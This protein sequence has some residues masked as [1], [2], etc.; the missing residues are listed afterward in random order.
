MFHTS[1]NQKKAGVTILISDKRDFRTQTILRKSLYTDNKVDIWRRYKIINMYAPSD[2]KYVKQTLTKCKSKCIY[3]EI[4]TLLYY[5]LECKV[6]QLL[7]KSWLFLRNLN[8]EFPINSV[9][10]LLG[11]H[12]KE[13][14]TDTQTNTGIWM[15]MAAW[16]EITCFHQ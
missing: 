4:E 15:L 7:L 16:L 2:T 5:W 11:I 9:L 1:G 8:T 13:R 14:K 12:P 6:V 10:Q 3:G